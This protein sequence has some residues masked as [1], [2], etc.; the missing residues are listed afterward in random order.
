MNKLK[1]LEVN[2]KHADYQLGEIGEKNT[3]ETL[4][5]Y[6]G[7]G[8]KQFTNKFSPFDFYKKDENGQLTHLWEL[9]TRRCNIDTY[10]T[11]CFGLSKKLYV[12]ELIKNTTQKPKVYII[13]LL[14][15]KENPKRRIHY[16]W[17]Y[18]K[19]REN[20]HYT[21]GDISNAKR[22]QVLKRAVFVKTNKLKP[23][24]QYITTHQRIL[25]A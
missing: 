13:W 22:N 25:S 5:E 21:I 20:T 4:R 7:D 11:L 15:M 14:E 23:I 10:P 2:F 16:I 19:K 12:D 8:V 24:L 1:E 17:R 3:L 6:W 9:K 18:K